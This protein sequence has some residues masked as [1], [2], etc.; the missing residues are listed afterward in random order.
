MEKKVQDPLRALF[1]YRCRNIPLFAVDIVCP[2]FDYFLRRPA[3][4][5]VSLPGGGTVLLGLFLIVK[6]LLFL[7]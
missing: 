4:P 5:V 7:R 1:S 3:P 2:L 6:P